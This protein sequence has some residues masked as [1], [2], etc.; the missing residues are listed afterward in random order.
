MRGRGRYLVLGAGGGLELKVFRRNQP[1]G[2]SPRSIPPRNAQSRQGHA[3]SGSQPRDWVEGYID[4]AL[5]R[6]FDGAACLLTRHFLP[7]QS[8]YA[9]F[10]EIHPRLAPARRSSRPLELSKAAGERA[11]GLRRYSA[12]A[13]PRAPTRLRRRWRQG[14]GRESRLLDPERT[15]R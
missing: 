4:D 7:R 13:W 11:N 12:F 9:P 10:R 2:G 6:T 15:L 14:S 3:G 8:D 1:A 5:R